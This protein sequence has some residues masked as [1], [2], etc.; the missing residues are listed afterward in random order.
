MNKKYDVVII[1]AGIGGLICGNILAKNGFKVLILEKKKRPGGCCA[2]FETKGFHFDAFVHAFGNFGKGAQFYSILE[3]LGLLDNIN[4]MR[5]DPNDVV[6]TEDYTINFWNDLSKTISELVKAFPLEEKSINVFLK[7]FI[8][9]EKFD[10]ISAVKNKTFEAILEKFFN[11]KKLIH[12]LSIFIL[13]NL[14]VPSNFASGFT[15]V[16]HYRQFIVDGG[17]YTKF[18]VQE[19]PEQLAENFTNLGGEILHSTPAKAIELDSGK[20]KGVFCSNGQKFLADFVVSNCDARH[21]FLKLLK[22]SNLPSTFVK[23][24]EQMVVSS[25]LFVVY[26]GYN[27]I[28]SF[29]PKDGASTWLISNYNYQSQYVINES[30]EPKTI[31]WVLVRPD[32]KKRNCMIVAHAPFGNEGYWSNNKC[33]FERDVIDL[34]KKYFKDIESNL[35]HKSSAD[36]RVIKSWTGNYRGSGYGWAC[37]ND[38][39]MD[40][41]FSNDSIVKNLFICGHWSTIAQGVEGVAIVGEFIAKKII[42][43]KNNEK[44]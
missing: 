18:G 33:K 31:E 5:F 25:S 42:K 7:E 26:L 32:Y 4:L 27:S 36:P 41:D 9:L 1:G 43:R 23:K 14:G 13:G 11:D 37:T 24:L 35:C 17:Y 44:T 10:L 29:M 6:I 2:V 38:Q 28:G 8:F 34:A 21:T 20:V 12:I 22:P 30:F 3:N 19:I 15:G 39:L 40:R 16:K